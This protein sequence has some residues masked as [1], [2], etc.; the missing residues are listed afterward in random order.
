MTDAEKEG[1]VKTI[2]GGNIAKLIENF[3]KVSTGDMTAFDAIMSYDEDYFDKAIEQGKKDEIF[4]YFYGEPYLKEG[5]DFT[6]VKLIQGS[7]IRDA[8]P[9]TRLVRPSSKG[10][11]VTNET[12]PKSIFE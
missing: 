5:V 7:E 12:G 8:I 1:A 4:E 2:G 6:P 9:K 10:T 3:G 11:N